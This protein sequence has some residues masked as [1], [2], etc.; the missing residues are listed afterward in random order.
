MN[1]AF[2]GDEHRRSLESI[3]KER[4]TQHRPVDDARARGLAR[5]DLMVN[6]VLERLTS[7]DGLAS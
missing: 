6:T 2:R 1:I 4:P 7:G 3:A 5:L